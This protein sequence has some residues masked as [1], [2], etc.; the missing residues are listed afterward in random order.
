MDRILRDRSPSSIPSRF[1]AAGKSEL[2]RLLLVDASGVR[3]EF[4]ASEWRKAKSYLRKETCGKCAYCEAATE[5][6]A[7][8]DVEHFRPKSV[9]WWLAYC[10]ENYLFCCQLCNQT[11]KGDAFPILGTRLKSPNPSLEAEIA[12]NW[13]DSSSESDCAAFHSSNLSELPILINPL[14]EDPKECFGYRVDMDQEWV[15]IEPR[16]DSVKDRAESTIAT[17]GLNRDELKLLRFERWLDVEAY[18]EGYKLGGR[19]RTIS[20]RGLRRALQPKAQFRAMAKHVVTEVHGLSLEGLW[21]DLSAWLR[22]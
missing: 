8:G 12:S 11:Y 16:S 21:P 22:P 15:L 9:Y 20:V 5:A 7:H 17:L 18:C 14:H 1:R 6:V 13:P 3:P 4:K 2:A 19:A 10:L